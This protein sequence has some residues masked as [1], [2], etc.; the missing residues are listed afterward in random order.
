MVRLSDLS[1]DHQ[2]QARE[3]LR[4]GKAIQGAGQ[5]GEKVVPAKLPQHDITER[6]NKTEARYYHLLAADHPVVWYEE[7]KFRIGDNCWY[8]PDFITIS[9]DGTMTAHET[10]GGFY[11]DDA[12]AKWKAVAEKYPN[13]RWVWA[14]YKKQEWKVEVYK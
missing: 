3:Q 13:I 11:R 12:R 1:P 5:G 6:M 2:R 9:H 14:A 10:K 8:T 4:G 7:I